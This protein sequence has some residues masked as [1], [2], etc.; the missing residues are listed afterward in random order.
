MMVGIKSPYII[1]YVYD[2]LFSAY[3]SINFTTFSYHAPNRFNFCLTSDMSHFPLSLS[4]LLEKFKRAVIVGLDGI[5]VRCHGLVI[6]VV[7]NTF[8]TSWNP[9]WLL[10]IPFCHTNT[11]QHTNTRSHT[12]TQHSQVWYRYMWWCVV[13]RVGRSVLLSCKVWWYIN[14]SSFASCRVTN[15]Q[16]NILL[17]L[18]I[19][20]PWYVIVCLSKDIIVQPNELWSHQKESEKFSCLLYEDRGWNQRFVALVLLKF[21][22]WVLRIVAWRMHCFSEC[23]VWFKIW[24]I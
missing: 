12:Y 17:V 8:N 13:W 22:W 19:Q 5:G 20:T 16:V 6:L 11:G 10:R 21:N 7:R 15:C 2:M 3:I 4:F 1:I 14:S 23:I 9:S 18:C 24:L